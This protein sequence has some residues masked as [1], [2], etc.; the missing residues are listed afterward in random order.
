MNC[1]EISGR[2]AG[3]VVCLVL[4]AVI[5]PIDRAQAI[6]SFARQTGMQCSACHTIYPQLTAVGRQFKLDGYTAGETKLVEKIS[7]LLEGSFTHTGAAQPGGAAPKFDDNDNFAF[8]TATF[9][10]GGKIAGKVGAFLQGTYDGVEKHWA[11][12]MM[13]VRYADDGT[14]GGK[15]VVYG[16]LVNN[17]P[18]LQ[19]LWNTTPVWRFPFDGSGLAPEPAA[20]TLLEGGLE[21]TALGGSAYVQWN[22]HLH[23]EAGLYHTLSR[24]V[25][26][27]LGV[28]PEGTPKSRH[29]A[30]YWRFAWEEQRGAHDFSV[31]VFGLH[32]ALFPDR[33]KS[34]GYDRITDFGADAQY[35][36]TG[37]RDNVTA[38][39][40]VINEKRHLLASF[41]LGNA[42]NLTNHLHSLN[43]SVTYTFDQTVGLTAGVGHIWGSRDAAL[44]GTPT[45]SPQTTSFTAEAA[46]VPLNKTPLG[47]Y[48]WFN[49][50]LTVQYVHYLK[51]DGSKTNVDGLGR[52]AADNDTLFILA[53]VTL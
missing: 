2:A 48:P 31:G 39:F 34:A 5:L 35:E 36:W 14:L 18:G 26:R 1:P 6:P 7:A 17:S 12:D 33:D 32:A 42:D 38:R 51:F 20:G 52:H 37:A 13:E 28:D 46:W 25:I 11:W 45:G 3:L 8:D 4:A 23:L 16:L 15:P 9:Y 19:D 53:T 43:T 10:Y 22:N 21:Q 27:S 41:A 50:K 44:Y 49:P 30:P 40:S 29:V 24:Q 47:V